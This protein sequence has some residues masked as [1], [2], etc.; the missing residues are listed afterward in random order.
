M[1][2]Q[3]ELRQTITELNL[4]WIALSIRILTEPKL[5]PMLKACTP[6]QRPWTNI[7]KLLLL[8]MP[9]DDRSQ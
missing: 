4:Q 8:A 9:Y 5:A 3:N 6:R 2:P 7:T 1:T